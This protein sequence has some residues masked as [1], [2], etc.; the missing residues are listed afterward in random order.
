MLDDLGR[1]LLAQGQ[2]AHRRLGK[3]QRWQHTHLGTGGGY[4]AEYIP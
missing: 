2:P 3:V 1:E 4:V